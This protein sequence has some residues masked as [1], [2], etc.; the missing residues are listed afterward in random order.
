MTLQ[1]AGLG[2]IRA[3]ILDN[4]AAHPKD[5]AKLAAA[6]F[7]I[8]RQAVNRHL[9][10]LIDE[11]LIEA[12]GKTRQRV[13]A[14]KVL[15]S[16]TWNLPIDSETQEHV[17]WNETAA[18]FLKTEQKNVH[19]ICSYGF[20]EMFNNIIDHSGSKTARV[21]LTMNAREITMSIA[22]QG[23]GLFRKI[24]TDMG[25]ANEN[26]AALELSK[27]KL[28]T[29]PKRHSGEGIFF[30]SRAFDGFVI[31]SGSILYGVTRKHDSDWVYDIGPRD[32]D[33][34]GTFVI[35]HISRRA[36]HELADIFARFTTP[37]E[38]HK[39]SRTQVFVNLAKYEGENLVSRSQAKRLMARVENFREVALLFDNVSEIGQAFAD[40]MF[41][42]FPSLHPNV[43]MEAVNVVPAVERMIR[44]VNDTVP[45]AREKRR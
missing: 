37:D 6:K 33:S 25:L 29:D 42:V 8:S 21:N 28:T 39:F 10:V 13:Y 4:L 43:R 31:N 9:H 41:R 5:V 2:A 38:D 11:G 30:T 16:R 36:T 12:K 19:D 26:E 7:K 22:D 24:M 40:E 17:V 15:V 18:P 27:G 14:L 20:T 35:M 34:P 3:F 1:A 44:R 32:G 23:I 45:I